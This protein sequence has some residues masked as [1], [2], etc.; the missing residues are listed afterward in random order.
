MVAQEVGF[1]EKN[2]FRNG[3]SSSR[4]PAGN[5]SFS[6]DPKFQY[7]FEDEVS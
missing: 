4:F 7:K 1:H 3:S 2:N 6:Q 5:I